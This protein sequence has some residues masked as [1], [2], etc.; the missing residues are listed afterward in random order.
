MLIAVAERLIT[1][2]GACDH[3]VFSSQALP[4]L[5]ANI[6]RANPTAA[7]PAILKEGREQLITKVTWGGSF[8]DSPPS[9]WAEPSIR[10]QHSLKMLPRKVE[11]VD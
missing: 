2:M 1:E 4:D 10:A 3:D 11:T 5:V 7:D 8:C 9:P 6:L